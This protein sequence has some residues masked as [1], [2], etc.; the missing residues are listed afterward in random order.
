MNPEDIQHIKRGV[1]RR[2]ARITALVAAIG[3]L[4]FGIGTITSD[5]VQKATA[6]PTLAECNTGVQFRTIPPAG[7]AITGPQ[8]IN[9]MGQN[10]V[11]NG[12]NRV[13]AGIRGLDNGVWITHLAIGYYPSSS[14]STSPGA[15]SNVWVN[16]GGQAVSYPRFNS[17]GGVLKVRVIGTDLNTY[18]RSL[19]VTGWG[20]WYAVAVGTAE[21]QG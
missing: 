6:A 4:S 1:P 8:L 13:W 2:I 16:L 3:L 7:G 14:S 17:F 18:G 19:D 15:W 21:V 5:P 12:E 10:L 20:P 11:G 9:P